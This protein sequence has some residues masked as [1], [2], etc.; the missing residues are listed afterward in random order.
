MNNVKQKTQDTRI[1]FPLEATVVGVLKQHIY[2][3]MEKRSIQISSGITSGRVLNGELHAHRLQKLIYLHLNFT[4][5][6][7]EKSS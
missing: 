4:L 2:T 6:I 5:M 1:D 7:E 3:C